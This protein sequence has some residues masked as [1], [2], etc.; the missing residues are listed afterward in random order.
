LHQ[1][2]GTNGYEFR[3]LSSVIEANNRQRDVFMKKILDRLGVLKGR[4]LAVW[5]VAFKPGTDDVRESAAVDIIRRLYGLGAEVVVF[6]PKAAENGKRVLPEVI[7]FAP[8]AI[9]ACEGAD[10]LVVLTE[11]PEFKEVSFST[12]KDRLIEPILFDGRNCLF[13]HHLEEQGFEYIGIGVCGLKT[14]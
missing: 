12:V 8:T 11:W 10:A 14:S 3:L 2:A 4:R 7:Q 5:G 9:D 6:D 13:D 1:I